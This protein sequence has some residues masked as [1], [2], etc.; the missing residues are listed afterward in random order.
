MRATTDPAG[1]GPL[2]SPESAP[3]PPSLLAA[4]AIVSALIRAGVRQ[5]VL[6]PGSRSAPLVPALTAA[7]RDGALRVRVVLDERTAGFVALGCARAELLSGSRR[8]AAVVTT[9]GTAVANL[10]PAVAEADAAGVPLLLVTADRPHEAVG[11]GANQ[12]T[13]QTRIFGAG[14]RTV[15]DLPADITADLG[16]S[17][18]TCAL[19]GQVRRAVDAA[20]G[21]LTND[22]G[23]VQ[24][25]VRFRPPLA[26]EIGGTS[27]SP[28]DAAT[29]APD[30]VA[31]V[32]ASLRLP[33]RGTAPAAGARPRR[34][35]ERGIVI[36]GDSVDAS[37][38]YARA[39]AEYLDWPLLAEPTS[40]ARGG[41]QALTRYAELLR[42]R[43]G[44]QLAQRVERVVVTGHPSLTR[45]ISALLARS[46]LRID[47]LTSTA[48]W[49]D[50]A[51]AVASVL[52]LRAVAAVPPA[53]GDMATVGTDTA[54]PPPPAEL[55]AALE[56]GP[57]PRGWTGR[58]RA[59]V[60]ALPAAD[61]PPTAGTLTADAAVT[62]VWDAAREAL[63]DAPL[64]VVGSSMTIRRLDRLA[65]PARGPAPAAIANRGLA[66]IDGTLATAL[67]AAVTAGP[68]RV[69]VGDL[70]FL[71]DAMSLSR[72]HLEAEPDL[73]VVVIDDG[74]GAIFSTLEYPHVI[75]PADFA[76][77]F[78]TP[79]ATDPGTLAAALGATVHR[80]ADLDAL[81]ELL[82]EPVRGLSVIHVHA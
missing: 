11:T 44:T 27:A 71:H 52:P 20:T 59:A 31:D 64:L 32:P 56:L 17:A 60:A 22:P 15:I 2:R 29:P 75:P 73:Q 7:E 6:A 38:R 78:S 18:G 76:R 54:V 13:E 12:T 9:S 68:V 50:V 21:A 69:V 40:G 19:A 67:G 16:E 39:L 48:R 43:R 55:A 57:G 4:R 30:P 74:G 24:L 62:A 65:A 35:A 23:P 61:A 8:P 41:P 42:S 72:G 70:A 47:A 25:N 58:W 80:P 66:G 77:Y 79:Q 46:D 5:V 53:R 45:P 81:R 51:G 36:A 1:T 82:A 26:L 49:T 14:P 63:E 10:H 37:G 3:A 34:R 28:T 33:P